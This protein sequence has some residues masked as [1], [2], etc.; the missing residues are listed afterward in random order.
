MSQQLSPKT[1]FGTG[2]PPKN[3]VGDWAELIE[4]VEFDVRWAM[5][6]Y[7]FTTGTFGSINLE[8]GIGPLG[9]EVRKWRS[10]A[11]FWSGGSLEF[12]DTGPTRYVPFNFRKDDRVSVRAA[13]INQSFG[14]GLVGQLQIFS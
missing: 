12:D 5:F 7:F 1:V 9:A 13:G 11:T 4:V 14:H 8:L 3:N 6:H 10:V 2:F